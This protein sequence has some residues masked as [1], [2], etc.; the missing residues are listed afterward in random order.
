[1]TDDTG[2]PPMIPLEQARRE[3]RRQ[4][5]KLTHSPYFENGRPIDL[6][7]LPTIDPLRWDGEPVPERRWIVEG[8]VPEGQVTMLGGDGGLGKSLIAI[9][10]LAACALGKSWLGYPVRPCKAIGIFCEDDRDELH[11]RF[12]DVLRHYGASFGDLESL[13]LLCRA[14]QDNLLMEFGDQWSAG[15]PTPFCTRIETLARDSGA[16]LLALDSLHDFFGGNENARPQARQF[17][18]SLRTIAMVMR[19]AVLLTAHPSL[20]GRNSGSGEAGSTA[21]N[22]AVRSRLY[23][24]APRQDDGDSPDRDYRELRTKKANYGASGNVLR[25]RWQDG[26]FG[27]EDQRIGGFVEVLELDRALME[28]LRSLISNG[29]MISAKTK[30]R[31][32]FANVLRDLPSCKKYSW[33][34]VCAAQD[35]LIANGKLVRVNAGPPSNATVYVR[36]V[37]MVYP[38]E[39]KA[40][41]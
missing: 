14:G 17:V 16:E 1:V 34:V 10:L 29:E 41:E 15:E 28:G 38:G 32:G 9:Q 6:Q 27:R 20:S 7:A 40:A 23:L 5:P 18:G 24:T 4:F 2:D 22:N 21:W 8:L 19:G 11:R 36:P 39:R 3:R 37:D 26:V 13:T 30:A 35:R 12:A 25:L 31:N 33:A